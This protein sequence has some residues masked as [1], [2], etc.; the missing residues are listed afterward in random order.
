MSSFVT[1]FSSI[2]ALP[3]LAV[4]TLGCKP[5]SQNVA[6]VRSSGGAEAA[7]CVSYIPKAVDFANEKGFAEANSVRVEM[8]SDETVKAA[9]AKF[10]VPQEKIVEWTKRAITP[11]QMGCDSFQKGGGAKYG[12]AGYK[13]LIKA[14]STAVVAEKLASAD[15][16]FAASDPFR[17]EADFP[18]VFALRAI[19]TVIVGGRGELRTHDII[20]DGTPLTPEQIQT[21]KGLSLEGYLGIYH[22][23]VP[24]KNAYDEMV[25]GDFVQ[26]P[27]LANVVPLLKKWQ[28]EVNQIGQRGESEAALVAQIAKASRACVS[29]HPFDDGNG[30]SC[31]VWA[32]W[33]LVR[34]NIPFPILWAGEDLFLT[35]EEYGKRF[36]EGVAA[37]R[38]L[39]SQL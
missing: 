23:D 33:A 11:T 18:D 12:A 27:R 21:V 35:P 29:I 32:Y 28:G 3:V 2:A 26:Y 5:Q 7:A 22:T 24:F 13:S 10:G 25:K 1:F 14:V 17:S 39:F 9:A 8:A 30:R 16:S 19:R 37:H 36:N 20:V 6:A 38:E 31:L 34:K 4:V 15:M